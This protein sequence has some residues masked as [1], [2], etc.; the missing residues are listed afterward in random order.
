MVPFSEVLSLGKILEVGHHRTE[1][2]ISIRQVSSAGGWVKYTSQF[3]INVH[4][5]VA[6]WVV[7]GLNVC[8]FLKFG[9]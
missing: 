7:G 2:W 9:A 1:N 6:T 4:E 8:D 3:G 5:R